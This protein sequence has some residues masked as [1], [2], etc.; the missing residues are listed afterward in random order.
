MEYNG[1][2]FSSSE[3]EILFFQLGELT[4]FSVV[5]VQEKRAIRKD[6]QIKFFID[7]LLKSSDLIYEQ[8]V[9][10]LRVKFPAACGVYIINSDRDTPSACGGVVH[11]VKKKGHRNS[12]PLF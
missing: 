3:I 8:G 11:L 4:R 10:S 6:I 9:K 12:A 5:E 1:D 7:V 2:P